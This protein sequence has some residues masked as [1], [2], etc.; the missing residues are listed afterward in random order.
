LKSKGTN[1]GFVLMQWH[2]DFEPILIQ[3]KNFMDIF[4]SIR[5]SIELQLSHQKN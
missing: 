2:K 5:N 3:E 1:V 4:E